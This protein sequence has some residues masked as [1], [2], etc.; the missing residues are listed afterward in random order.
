M[1]APRSR[2]EFSVQSFGD[3]SRFLRSGIA[4]EESRELRESLGAL[5]QQIDEMMRLRRGTPSSF[6]ALGRA[7]EDRIQRRAA[8]L[9]QSV[10]THQR[11]LTGL[12]SAWHTLYEMGAYQN[13]LRGLK[14]AVDVWHDAL[15]RRSSGEG[16]AYARLEPLA[17]RTLGEGLL[18]IDMY[19]QGDSS[20][21]EPGGLAQEPKRR[22]GF[23]AGIWRLLRRR[24]N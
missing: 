22:L 21:S 17:W 8:R 18:L 6:A 13:A 11:L 10:Q 15:V 12:G 7:H 3:V 4:D 9:A 14:R 5:A 1:P 24:R 16:D 20:A 23:W 19:E 2:T